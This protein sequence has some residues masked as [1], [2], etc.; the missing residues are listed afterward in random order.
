MWPAKNSATSASASVPTL[1]VVI[2]HPDDESYA[3]GGTM[4][5]ASAAGWR[6]VTQAATNGENGERHDGPAP[7]PVSLGNRRREEL[8][9]SC[10][11]LGAESPGFWN[12]PDGSLADEGDQSQRIAGLIRGENADVVL[13]LGG[14]GAYGHPDHL[15]VHRWVTTAIAGLGGLAP[16]LLLANFPHGLFLPQYRL[17]I[18]M[19]GDPPFPPAEAIGSNDPD[20]RLPIASVRDQKLAA[21]SAHRTQLNGGDPHALFPGGI[22]G[23]V[24]G[25]ER[26]T[27]FDARRSGAAA[28]FVRDIGGPNRANS[29]SSQAPGGGLTKRL[30]NL[31]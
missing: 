31:V 29:D 7:E 19:L 1:L 15:A 16:P 3:F 10:R 9:E 23:R 8:R 26:Y 22:V 24:L 14:D 12:L 21:I 13:A 30:Q 18:G 11:V 4:A 5:L 20:F 6:V 2:P 25:E 27:L 17:C 28:A